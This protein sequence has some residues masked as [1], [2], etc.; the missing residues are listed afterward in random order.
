MNLSPEFTYG[1]FLILIRTASMLV[2]APLLS[3]RS[4][5][6]WMR[7]GF[8]VFFSL[9]MV[10]VQGDR[11]PEPPAGYGT[12]AAAVLSET[13]LGLGLGMAMQLIFIGLQMGSHIIGLQMGFSLGAVFDPVSGAQFGAID[14]FFSILVTL[15][16]FTVNGHHMVIQALAETLWAIPPGSF[17]PLSLQ[18][19]AIASL[20]SGLFVTALRVAMPVVVALFVTDVGMGFVARTMPQAN[21]LIVGLPIK[22]GVGIIVLIAA[23]PA[24]TAL[25]TGV[26]GGSLAGS[27]LRLLGAR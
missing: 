13:L 18:S 17:D 21:V 23:L 24:T 5:P 27:S 3:H 9:V 26:I 22:I 20:V 16:F 8:A 19:S 12:L 25:M 6:A 10:P 2:S 4:I 7:I 15:V 11:L 14:Q 1:F